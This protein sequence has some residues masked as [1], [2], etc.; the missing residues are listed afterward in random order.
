LK[1]DPWLVGAAVVLAPV[2]LIRR[3]TRA[4]A[5]AYV[6]QVLMVLR[7]GYLPGMYVI[8][9][10]PF[11]ALV[12]AGSMEWIWCRRPRS[13]DAPVRAWCAAVAIVALAATLAFVVAPAWR[14]GD[15]TATTLRRDVASRTAKQWVLTHISHHHRVIVDDEFWV[16]LIQHGYD[17]TPVRG[18]FFSRTIVS[19]WPLDYDPAVR[20]RFRRSW[21]DFEYIISTPPMRATTD[22]TPQTAQALANS[23]VLV[24]FG[25][26]PH[27]IQ[28]RMIHR[29]HRP[30]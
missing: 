25:D 26:G 17:A 21:R 20:K 6:I 28:V 19:Y 23:R 3:S 5:L 12:V 22:R 30:R 10:L 8:A 14:V 9:L 11:A 16:Y 18:G 27:L 7:P 13:L 1:L 24:S 29:G 15:G 2:A 4:V